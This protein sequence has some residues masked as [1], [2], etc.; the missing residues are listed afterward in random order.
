VAGN[1]YAEHHGQTVAV[2]KGARRDLREGLVLRAEVL[3]HR[4]HFLPDLAVDLAV[5]S[6]LEAASPRPVPAPVT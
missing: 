4:A 5:I 6:G 1:Q 3:E 2:S